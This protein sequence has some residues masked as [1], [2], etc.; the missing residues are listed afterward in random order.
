MRPSHNDQ[1]CSTWGNYHFK[2]FD[3]DFFQLPYTCNYN[4]V[5]HCKA[6]YESFNIQLQ[7]QEINRVTSIK[8]VTMKLDGVIVELTKPSIKV[9]DLKWVCFDNVTF[10]YQM[11]Y[12]LQWWLIS[13]HHTV[14]IFFVPSSVTLPFNQAGISIGRT[15]SYV[16]IE[17]KLGLVIMWNEED[18]LWVCVFFVIVHINNV[19][20][21]F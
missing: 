9:N 16:K 21:W 4:L 2:T 14:M 6:S 7:R 12:W 8:M 20:Y 15:L 13:Y 19:W 18:S 5:S 17:S 11:M 3:G 1:F 10:H